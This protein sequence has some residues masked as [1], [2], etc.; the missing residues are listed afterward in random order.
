V[1]LHSPQSSA[2]LV[3]LSLASHSPSP[4][5]PGH[6][7]QSTAHVAHVSSCAHTRSPQE[8]QPP[9][10]SR[11]VSQVSPESQSPSPHAAPQQSGAHV[12][13]VS[14][15]SQKSSPQPDGLLVSPLLAEVFSS[16]SSPSSSTPTRSTPLHAATSAASAVSQRTNRTEWRRRIAS[17]RTGASAAPP[18]R[19]GDRG[20][21]L[22]RWMFMSGRPVDRRSIL[23]RVGRRRLVARASDAKGSTSLR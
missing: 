11:H 20:G 23:G 6:S 12:S 9:Q 13:Q 21:E 14:F 19:R 16:S 5:L 3:Q 10:S 1:A 17:A 4:Q 15:S 7:P 22:A 8:G 2:Q 18:V